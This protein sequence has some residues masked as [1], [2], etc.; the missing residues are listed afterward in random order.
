MPCTIRWMYSVDIW[1]VISSD[2]RRT[3]FLNHNTKTQETLIQ[4]M[5]MNYVLPPKFPLDKCLNKLNTE[6]GLPMLINC[7]YKS[8]RKYARK[9][10]SPHN[11]G[12]CQSINT[13]CCLTIDTNM[14]NLMARNLKL[15]W[16]YLSGNLCMILPCF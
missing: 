16:R 4:E 7:D 15:W 2:V 10:T 12:K 3:C 1:C 13:R 6:L 14:T 8:L 5:S 11:T 9:R